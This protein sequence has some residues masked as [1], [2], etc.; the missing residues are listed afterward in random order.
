MENRRL[1]DLDLRDTG[2]TLVGQDREEIKEVKEFK[3]MGEA[4]EMEVNVSHT[5][6][7][8][9]RRMECLGYLRKQECQRVLQSNQ[10]YMV[11]L[12]G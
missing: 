4:V 12:C 11:L 2:T 5:L 6:N 10:R 8:R 9:E 1:Q 7:E 3:G